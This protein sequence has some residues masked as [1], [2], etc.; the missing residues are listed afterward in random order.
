[1]LLSKSVFAQRIDIFAN[2]HKEEENIRYRQQISILVSKKITNLNLS[3]PINM[4]ESIFKNK[5]HTIRFDFTKI[6]F[7]SACVP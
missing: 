2:I 7:S 3:Q 1:M 4:L 6:V 5:W